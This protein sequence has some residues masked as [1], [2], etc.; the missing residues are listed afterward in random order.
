MMSETEE[1][2]VILQLDDELLARLRPFLKGLDI[3]I[4]LHREW[5]YQ[6]LSE[7]GQFVGYKPLE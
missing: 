1:C 3:T 6:A 5:V 2:V 7:Q 4:T